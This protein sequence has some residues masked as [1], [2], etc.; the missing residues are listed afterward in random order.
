MDQTRIY[1]SCAQSEEILVF[2][3]DTTSGEL[4][5]C[6]QVSVPGAATPLGLGNGQGVLYAGLRPANTLLALSLDPHDGHLSVLGSSVVEGGP[7]YVSTDHANRVVFSASHGGSCL[8]VSPLDAQGVPGPMSQCERGVKHAHAALVDASNRWVLVPALG[9]DAI[10]IYRLDGTQLLPHAVAACRAGSGPRHPVLS[11]DNTHLWCINECDG[12]VDLF[13]FD[14]QTGALELRQTISLLP[15]DFAGKAWSSELRITADN[16]F[17]YATDRTASLI[18][19]FS[20]QPDGRMTL[21]GYFPT[22]AQPRGMAVSPDGRWLAAAGQQSHHLSLYAIDPQTGALSLHQRMAA[23][24]EPI[25]VE[26][27]TLQG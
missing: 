5:L 11:A 23:G 17:L 7:T 27:I 13:D 24:N 4:A 19:A 26:I 15:A 14:A 22:E 25:M 16:R 9:E 3:L 8:C 20:L 12:T 6:Q 21:V 1:V 18:T 10:R 2:S